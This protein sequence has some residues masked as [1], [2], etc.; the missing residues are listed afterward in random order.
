MYYLLLPSLEA[1]TR[2]I[3]SLKERQVHTVFHY[4]PL[5][6]SPAGQRFSRAHGDLPV[7]GNISERLVR[8]PLWLGLEDHMDTVL[9]AA[10]EALATA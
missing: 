3:A 10:D 2:F 4:I 6:S 5:H 8:L 1:R 9:E 7:T